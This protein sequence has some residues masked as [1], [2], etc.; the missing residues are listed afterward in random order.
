MVYIYCLHSIR[1]AMFSFLLILSGASGVL[2]VHFLS[3]STLSP[4]QHS[5]DIKERITTEAQNSAKS[6]LKP[7]F[8]SDGGSNTYRQPPLQ[9]LQPRA[10]PTK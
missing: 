7:P 2:M 3:E 8:L 9:D 1:L 4:R 6:S 5:N 10:V